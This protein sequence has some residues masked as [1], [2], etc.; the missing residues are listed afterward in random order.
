MY[1]TITN[2]DTSKKDVIT[3]TYKVLI[4][5]VGTSGSGTIPG[6]KDTIEF[7]DATAANGTKVGVSGVTLDSTGTAVVT[8]NLE[9]PNWADNV[10]ITGVVTGDVYVNG[11]PFATDVEFVN[12]DVSADGKLKGTNNSVNN[13]PAGA[14]VKV[15][16]T[17][18]VYNGVLIVYQDA[19]GNN[20]TTSGK[21]DVADTDNGETIDGNGTHFVSTVEADDLHVRYLTTDL[22]PGH[23]PTVTVV[24]GLKAGTGTVGTV[25]Y[26]AGNGAWGVTIKNAE[27][28]GTEAVVIQIDDSEI[29]P[30][31]SIKPAPATS[32]SGLTGGS[33]LTAGTV[34][35]A[36]DPA[37]GTAGSSVIKATIASLPSTVASLKLSVKLNE[38]GTLTGT[39]TAPGNVNLDPVVTLDKNYDLTKATITVSDVVIKLA[40]DPDVPVDVSSFTYKFTFNHNITL[41]PVAGKTNVDLITTTDSAPIV[42]TGVSA[43]GKV[44]TVVLPKAPASGKSIK[45]ADASNGT[46]ECADHSD[47]LAAATVLYTTT[48]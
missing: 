37:S 26:D 33:A 47:A 2:K 9:V 13:I 30:T 16:I 27:A 42:P 10:D 35:L 19:K 24:S 38:G 34:A 8:L 3:A 1:L 18:V 29:T 46:I 17:S 36:G 5:V 39:V 44:L 43:S 15:V 11:V 32:L 25:A 40:L 31:W 21:L 14:D 22:T 12:D 7:K 41:K 45:V 28:L 4:N 20:I 48:P 23:A 6:G